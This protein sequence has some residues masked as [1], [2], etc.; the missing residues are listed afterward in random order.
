MN[1]VFKVESVKEVRGMVFSGYYP[2]K[3]N[4]HHLY[5]TVENP[6]ALLIRGELDGKDTSFFSPTVI[7]TETTGFL[8]Y[9]DMTPNSWFL[10]TKEP[11]RGH[12]G[13]PMFDNGT[14]PNLA[15]ETPSVIT[16]KINVG[17]VLN[18][19]FKPKGEFN[20]TQTIKNVK[21]V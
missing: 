8:N 13:H 2:N 1:G 18:I 9:K 15:I 11:V 5:T 16:S 4:K 17:D 10:Q 19:S 12:K 7:V 3:Y 21:I 14:T 6:K 20:G